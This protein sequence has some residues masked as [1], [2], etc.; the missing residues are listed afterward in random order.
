VSRLFPEHL[1]VRLAAA[2]LNVV[3]LRGLLRKVAVED[4]RVPC[5]PAFGS[6]RWQG[7][8][9]ALKTLTLEGNCRVTVVLSNDFVR[10]AL[11]PWSNALATPA[12]EEA[13]VRHHFAKVHGERAKEWLLRSSQSAAGAPRLASAIDRKLLE[14]IQAS[15]PRGGKAR[16]VSVQPQLMNTFNQHRASIPASGAW[17]VIAEAERACVALHAGGRWRTVQNAKGAW[18]ALLDRERH[19]VEGELPDLVL[20][21]GAAAPSED[22]AWKFRELAA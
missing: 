13:Y 16:L 17:L 22:S 9:E 11:V 15:F 5:D 4:S 10:Y 7:A 1:L 21:A 18:H 12:E 14:E 3:R 6:E 20:L 19:R 2:E 8:V